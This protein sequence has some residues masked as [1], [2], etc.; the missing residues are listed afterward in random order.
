MLPGQEGIPNDV[1][2]A[3]EALSMT[4]DAIVLAQSRRQE[5]EFAVPP[6]LYHYTDGA[7][8]LG[9]VSS[10]AIWLTDIF[11]LN[12]PSEIRHGIELALGVFEGKV[13]A[14]GAAALFHSQFAETLR[15]HIEDIATMF[16]ASFSRS[17]DDL[18]QWRAYGNNGCG[19]ALGFEGASIEKTFAAID[20]S[21]NTT[22]QIE[23]NESYLREVMGS[24]VSPAI[25]LLSAT[26]SRGLSEEAIRPFLSFVANALGVALL[27]VAL[28]FKHPGYANEVEYRFLQVRQF[29]DRL[30][31]LR[32]RARGLKL[33]RYAV[34]EWKHQCPD[35][36]LEVVIG[37]AAEESSARAFV[38]EC[39]KLAG[40][41]PGRV[42]VS[43]SGI[44]YRA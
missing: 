43:K 29:G 13:A 42:M 41:N 39:L 3:M 24:L 15:V 1:R 20:P 11:G 25:S 34:F 18:G 38:G 16:V 26:E 36:L 28:T 14:G 5:Q 2:E 19:F 17:G 12:D 21:R 31:D 22:I 30:D 44:P 37:P 35:A 40:L 27:H 8:L 9:V 7:G 33:I 23:Y 4:L 6:V 32:A 10:G